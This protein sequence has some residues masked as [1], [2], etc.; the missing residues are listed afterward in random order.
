MEEPMPTFSMADLV[1]QMRRFFLAHQP[2]VHARMTEPGYAAKYYRVAD[3]IRD[4]DLI[5]HLAGEITLASQVAND[6]MA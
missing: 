1:G 3:S 5:A 6:G 2:P 4:V